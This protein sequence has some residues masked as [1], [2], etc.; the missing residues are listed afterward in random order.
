[1]PAYDVVI[2]ARNEESTVGDVVRAARGARGVGQVVVVDDGSTDGTAAA[3]WAA[4]ASV[5]STRRAG[6][7]K[8]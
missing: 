4:G 3:A 2:P 7:W 8:Y 6:N 5:V 1:M